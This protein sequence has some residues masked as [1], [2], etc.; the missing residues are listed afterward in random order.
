MKTRVLKRF[1][2]LS[3]MMPC[4]Q[5]PL[6]AQPGSLFIFS[7]PEAVHVRWNAP[8]E[9]PDLGFHVERA[10]TPGGSWSRLTAEPVRR[11]EDAAEIRRRLGAEAESFLTFFG[12]VPRID[13][14]RFE[15]VMSSPLARSLIQ[16]QSVKTP[17]L[18]AVLG[19]TFEDRQLV[20]GSSF[21]YR[22]LRVDAGGAETLWAQSEELVLHGRR[23][24]VSVPDGLRGQA[25]DR[26]A[27]LSWNHQPQLSRSGQTVGYRVYRAERPFGPFRPASAE[28]IVPSRVDGELP[29]FLFADR[30]LLNDVDYWYRVSSVNLAGF[31][32]PPTDAILIRPRA[33]VL[34]PPPLD[35]AGRPLEDAV[36]LRWTRPAAEGIEGFVIYRATQFEGPYQPVGLSPAA[37]SS[38]LDRDVSTGGIYWYYLTSQD[39]QANESEPSDKVQVFLSDAVPPVAPEGVEAQG[40]EEGI[41]ISWQPNSESDL[42]GYVVERT[43]RI[44]RRA[45]ETRADGPFFTLFTG[46]TTETSYW[47]PVSPDS[48]TRYA[49]RVVALDRSWN[50]S[51]A[52]EVVFARMPDIVPPPSPAVH[53]ARVEDGQVV[54]RWSGPL[55]EDLAGFWVYRTPESAD[56]GQRLNKSL[57][58]AEVQSYQDATAEPGEVYVYAVSA[59]DESGNEG[60]PSPGVRLEFMDLRAPEPP[61]NV[62]IEVRG[63]G[64]E[65]SWR[66]GGADS[67]ILYRSGPNEGPPAILTQLEGET[68]SYLDRDVE[69]GSTYTY[70]LR[71]LD[72]SGNLSPPSEP[73]SARFE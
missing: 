30:F 23:D 62:R 39:G 14:Q 57:L 7:Q 41:L 10:E 52:S 34:L 18:A 63:E 50:R 32:S 9:Q 71:A 73:A 42:E 12:D 28:I 44:S 43:T 40:T 69:R 15:E 56:R 19:E 72:P 33:T 8:L 70:T 26:R 3:V 22:I 6:P 64:L 36:Y 2:L 53:S 46:T 68:T 31:E 58:A 29:E 25:G 1:V 45:E 54:L 16:L 48:Q 65:I 38:F 4:W 21:R 20:P 24:E 61:Q 60:D 59:Q 49:Y 55:A 37:A 67:L 5:S 35:L 66:A 13:A 11:L 47:D 27:L 17:P 51:A